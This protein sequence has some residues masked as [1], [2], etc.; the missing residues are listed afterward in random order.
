MARFYRP[1]SSA[2]KKDETS[3]EAAPVTGRVYLPPSQSPK[4]AAKEAKAAARAE[5]KARAEA[6]AAAEEAK[7]KAAAGEPEPTPTSTPSTL[8]DESG[9]AAPAKPE[10]EPA[11]NA[12]TEAWAE[13][14]RTRKGAS[15]DDLLDGDGQP[16]GRN[17]L[18]EKYGTPSQ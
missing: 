1:E 13:Y 7:A 12:T 6:E 9:A 4:A 18:R 8:G 2:P 16:L 3:V 11:A 17:A 15:P 14:A 5:A 10:D